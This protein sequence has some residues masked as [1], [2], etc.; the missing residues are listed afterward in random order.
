MPTLP[1]LWLY[2]LVQWWWL[3]DWYRNVPA[4]QPCSSEPSEQ[5]GLPSQLRW[6][7]I[8]WPDPR[9]RNSSDRQICVPSPEHI[10]NDHPINR[11]SR[12]YSARLCLNRRRMVVETSQNVHC[13]AGEFNRFRWRTL[14]Q[15][16]IAYIA[17]LTANCICSGTLRHRQSGCLICITP[18]CLHRSVIRG[19]A[20][21][22]QPY[23]VL[24]CHLIDS[25]SIIHVNTW[26]TVDVIEPVTYCQMLYS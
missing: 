20:L 15:W 6:A 4:A 17:P 19:S 16:P 14:R 26:I 10:V 21:A 23:V 25:T 18:I 7:G 13:I 11:T 1:F 24:V 3:V 2:I 8:Q 12:F 22:I 5:S 9:H